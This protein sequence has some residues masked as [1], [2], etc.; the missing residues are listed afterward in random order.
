MPGNVDIMEPMDAYSVLKDNRQAESMKR[1]IGFALFF[2]AVG[3]V[4]NM[5]MPNLFVSILVVVLCLLVGFQLF[6]RC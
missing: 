2:V 1:V 4:I 5:F 3:M 6:C